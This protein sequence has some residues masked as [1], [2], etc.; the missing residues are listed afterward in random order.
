MKLGE[1][2]WS[3]N[4]FF[5]Q[6]KGL[7]IVMLKVFFFFTLSKVGFQKLPS[8]LDGVGRK[9]SDLFRWYCTRKAKGEVTVVWKR[10]PTV[11]T[12]RE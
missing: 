8:L 4:C 5:A 11:W 6:G 3:R 12:W 1:W 9:L 10:V 7:A 2:P